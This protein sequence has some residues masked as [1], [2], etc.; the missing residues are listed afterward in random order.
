MSSNK[1]TH[2]S[3]VKGD[4]GGPILR[5]KLWFYCVVHRLL[6]RAVH[7]RVR[8]RAQRGQPEVFYTR[9]WG[10]TAPNHL[11]GDRRT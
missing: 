11:P 5:D 3:D 10:P 4:L 6:R 2:Y 1:Y 7:H 8:L 9:L